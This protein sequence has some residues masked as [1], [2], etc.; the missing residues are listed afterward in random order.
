MTE[1]FTEETKISL[2]AV[3]AASFTLLASAIV[4]T[5]YLVTG[6]T[7]VTSKADQTEARVGRVV[8]VMLRHNEKVDASLERITTIL[9]RLARIEQKLDDRNK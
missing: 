2:F 7:S 6:L 5:I 4:T 3:I 8:D 9:E 1:V